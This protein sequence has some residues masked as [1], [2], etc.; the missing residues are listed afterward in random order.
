MKWLKHH[1]SKKLRETFLSTY[2]YDHLVD[3]GDWEEVIITP[4][5]AQQNNS[6]MNN[7]KIH[8]H[9]NT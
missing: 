1:R 5:T 2:N 9:V 7:N 8:H 4:T 6:F 3:Q